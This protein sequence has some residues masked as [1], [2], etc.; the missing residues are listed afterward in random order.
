MKKKYI[1]ALFRR[2]LINGGVFAINNQLK[3]Q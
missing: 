3:P 1:F 2:I